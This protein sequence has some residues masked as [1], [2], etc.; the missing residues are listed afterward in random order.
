LRCGHQKVKKREEKKN[1]L[2]LDKQH[3]KKINLAE[4]VRLEMLYSPGSAVN[5]ALNLLLIIYG[6][7]V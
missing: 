4:Q 5:I 7:S 2:R 1:E 3:T 6:E